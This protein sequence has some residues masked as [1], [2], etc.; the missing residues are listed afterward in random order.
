MKKTNAILLTLSLFFIAF[1]NNLQAQNLSKKK[2]KHDSNYYEMYPNKL[3]GRIY[4][5]KKFEDINVPSGGAATDLK[6]VANHKMNFG[7]GVTW[8][9]Y[10][11]NAFYGFNNSSANKGKTKGLDLQLHLFPHKWVIDVL[12]V[13]PKGMYIKPKGTAAASSSSYY[14]DE[15]TKERIYG[16]AAYRVPNKEKFSY[17]AALVQNE[18][19]KKSAG[20]VL[21]GLEAYYVIGPENDSTFIPKAIQDG[22][23][24]KGY[25]EMR[26]LSIGPGIGYAYTAV[27][28]Q[29]F[30]IMGSL[31]ANL[32]VNSATEETPDVVKKTSIA[33]SS[34]YKAAIGYN[35]DNWSF[36]VSTAGNLLW[37][38]GPASAQTYFY[39]AGQIKVSLA[40][41]FDVKKKEKK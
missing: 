8:R 27:M 21:Y 18:W 4:T 12:A 40:K 41:K 6:Y 28:D 17:R 5:A 26:Y 23:A 36:V 15:E 32:K 29:H 31:I 13:M 24:E 22:Y 3:T 35:S 19:Q 20:S 14:S 30:F 37:G 7:I 10:S 11:I 34:I 1:S 2:Y 33:P 25:L 9:N 16:V 39:K 38:K